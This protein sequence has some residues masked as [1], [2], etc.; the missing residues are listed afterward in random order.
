[1]DIKDKTA[2]ASKPVSGDQKLQCPPG[3]LDNVNSPQNRKD[4]RQPTRAEWKE[5]ETMLQVW[6]CTTF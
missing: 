2:I 4:S 6:K 5:K 1:M 3:H